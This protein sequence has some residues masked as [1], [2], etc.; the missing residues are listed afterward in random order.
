MREGGPESSAGGTAI[1]Y[2]LYSVVILLFVSVINRLES[3]PAVASFSP[4][5]H[6]ITIYRYNICVILCACVYAHAEKTKR[7][8]L[9]PKW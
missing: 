4:R 1:S 8:P 5:K 6:E 3:L 9:L 2:N 7:P